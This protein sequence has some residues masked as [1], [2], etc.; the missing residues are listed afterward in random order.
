MSTIKT[1]VTGQVEFIVP[2]GVGI[3]KGQGQK[4]TLTVYADDI[5]AASNKIAAFLVNFEHAAG[6]GKDGYQVRQ[7]IANRRAEDD[8]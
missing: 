7:A 2:D 3:C 8:R 6:E 1:T 5:E 4:Y